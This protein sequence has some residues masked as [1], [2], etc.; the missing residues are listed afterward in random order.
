MLFES[1]LSK[2][3]ALLVGATCLND[4]TI[5][6][7]IH[8]TRS[9]CECPEC[10]VLSPRVHSRYV[11]QPADL[12]VCGYRVRLI[13]TVRRFF[14]DAGQCPRRTF[15]ERL[16]TFL[17]P[18]ARRT[19]RL[20]GQ[21]L[22][23]AFATG[24]EAGSRL[25]TLLAMPASATTLLRMIRH[26]PV[27]TVPTPRVLGIDDWAKRKGHT[28]GTILVDLEAHRVV[29]ILPEATAETVEL[30]LK[31]HPGVE[32]V[33]RD[34]GPEFVKGIQDGAP[35]AIP[36]ADRWHLLKN[37][38][39]T[40]QRWL[41]GKR[42]CLRAA[43]GIVDEPDPPGQVD[44][45]DPDSANPEFAVHAPG[46]ARRLVRY[47]AVMDLYA[48][49]WS[50][51]DIAR[52]L[53][54]GRRT[55]RLYI[56]TEGCPP[57]TQPSPRRSKLD[58]YKPY[59]REVWS[60]G[61]HNGK[62]ILREIRAQG[63]S[64]CYTT[65]TRWVSET[66]RA[67][68]PRFVTMEKTRPWSPRRGAWLMTRQPEDLTEEDRDALERMFRAETSTRT[69]YDLVQRF[70]EMVRERRCEDLMPWIDD[71]RE[72]ETTTFKRFVSGIMRD[73]DAVRNALLLPWSNG[74]TE[75]QVN[76]LKL[77][78]RQMYGRAA[79]DLLQKRVLPRPLPP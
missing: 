68:S 31:T 14:C 59:I 32:V 7:E 77:I 60:A 27:A 78:K 70:V 2:A 39:D 21:Q 12:P 67:K 41:T 62:T 22:H 51:S 11:R 58:P 65:M 36:V 16:P 53:G 26:A 23:V 79:F 24:G 56:R 38:G 48:E 49:G 1:L 10:G 61:C 74:Q 40:L 5:A 76:R 4:K 15:A 13:F 33:T 28:Y 57:S 25:L 30:W 73:L 18:Y 44:M 55:V 54:L 45:R 75:G 3:C 46:Y 72:G 35:D 6:I 50:Q 69:V 52:R 37:L 63:Y 66:L 29:D 20:A 47:Q 71:V 17:A 8:S 42:S 19:H 9:E 64:G 34:R 43:A